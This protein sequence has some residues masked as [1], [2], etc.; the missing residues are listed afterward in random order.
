MLALSRS[1]GRFRTGLPLV[2]SSL[3][4]RSVL[5]PIAIDQCLFLAPATEISVG[6]RATVSTRNARGLNWFAG[7]HPSVLNGVTWPKARRWHKRRAT[8][9]LPRLESE[10]RD[11]S[12]YLPLVDGKLWGF[13][14]GPFGAG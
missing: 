2:A 6:G 5:L 3:D 12:S 8:T 10:R 4:S 7:H 1:Q 11:D 9:L 13:G 14:T